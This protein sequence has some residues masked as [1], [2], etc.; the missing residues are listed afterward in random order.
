MAKRQESITD[1][2]QQ[3]PA[4]FLDKIFGYEGDI[5]TFP[6]FRDAFIG[7]FNTPRGRNA[8]IDEVNEQAIIDL[9]EGEECKKEMKNKLP[10]KDYEKLYGDGVMVQREVVGKKVVTI[11]RPKISVK[12]YSKKGR[13]IPAYNKGYQRWKPA[14]VRFLKVRKAKKISPKQIINQ[15]NAHF[16]GHERTESSLKTKVYRI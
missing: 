1:A 2:M 9:F 10:A 5:K 16:S 8:K 6:E 3:E 12:S 13:T 7:A 4:R 15:Y 14:E 11:T